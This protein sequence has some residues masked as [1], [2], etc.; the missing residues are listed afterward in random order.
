[1]RKNSRD[2][3]IKK[4]KK[5]KKKKQKKT[6]SNFLLIMSNFLLSR[7]L[8]SSPRLHNFDSI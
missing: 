3:I 2:R 5:K 6:Y 7:F 8:L 1:M 4:K